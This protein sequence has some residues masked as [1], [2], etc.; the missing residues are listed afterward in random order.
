MAAKKAAVQV[1]E[2][3]DAVQDA[4]GGAVDGA[5]HKDFGSAIRLADLPPLSFDL[6]E[7]NFRCRPALQSRKILEFVRSAD[8][9]SETAAGDAIHHFIASSLLPDDV[10]AWEELLDSDEYVV[11]V[12]MLGDIVTWLIEQYSSRPTQQ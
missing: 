7:M 9:G 2:P 3:E 10:Q 11:D 5:R 6:C 4:P 1:L 8:S 12:Q